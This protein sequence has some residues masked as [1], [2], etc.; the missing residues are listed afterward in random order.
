MKILYVV[1]EPWFFL[2]HRLPTA[3]AAKQQ[4]DT[5]HVATRNGIGVKEIISNGFVHH[6]IP[7][8]RNGSSVPSE[9]FSL[10]AIWKLIS[11][12]KTDIYK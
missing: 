12:I 3:L 8:S 5:V 11:N 6:E 1:N 9:L 2:S 7:L 4:G 10:L